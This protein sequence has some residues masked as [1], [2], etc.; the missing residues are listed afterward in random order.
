MV[1]DNFLTVYL[2]KG[3]SKAMGNSGDKR[4]MKSLEIFD[5]ELRDG[6]RQRKLTIDDVEKML[7]KQLTEMKEALMAKAGE[8][9]AEETCD[10]VESCKECG[11]TLKKTKKRINP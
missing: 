1:Y 6:L 2:L 3:E 9:L 7:G 5:E 8:I 10:T 4:I 11:T